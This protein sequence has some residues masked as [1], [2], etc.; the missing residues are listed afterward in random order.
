MYRLCRSRQQVTINEKM[1]LIW[2]ENKTLPEVQY[3]R[4]FK[5]IPMARMNDGYTSPPP[6]YDEKRLDS[7]G[8]TI[9]QENSKEI[10]RIYYL[11]LI[12]IGYSQKDIVKRK[13]GAKYPYDI[14]LINQK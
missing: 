8:I 4:T 13:F 3:I 5:N 2:K 14:E 1:K 6:E 7:K 9:V 12:F 11:F 10:S